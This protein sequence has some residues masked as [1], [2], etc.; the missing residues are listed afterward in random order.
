MVGRVLGTDDATPLEF[1]VAVA[2]GSHLQLD[3][4]VAF[5]RVLPA[6][7]LLHIYGIVGH[8]RARHEGARFPPLP[9]AAVRKEAHDERAAALDFESVGR[10]QP[11]GLCRGNQPLGLEVPA[12]RGR[13]SDQEDPSRRGRTRA[14]LWDHPDRRAADSQRG[15]ASHRGEQR[16]TCGRSPR[17][18]RGRPRAARVAATRTASA[19]AHLVARLDVRVAATPPDTAAVEF[20]PL[21]G[22]PFCRGSACAT[23]VGAPADPSD[24]LSLT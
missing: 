8:V 15:R 3:D 2:P 11:A 7:E 6:G 24:G 5:D 9:G 22:H 18:G 17:P 19:V 4:V 12:L 1:W 14:Q 16:C 21:L 13:Q 23:A 10:K 20:L